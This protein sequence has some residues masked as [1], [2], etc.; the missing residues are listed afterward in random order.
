MSIRTL[1]GIIADKDG[2][3]PKPL[4]PPA[5]NAG[6]PFNEQ[7][8]ARGTPGTSS[9]VPR[10]LRSPVGRPGPGVVFGVL[11]FGTVM[12]LGIFAWLAWV[13][14][15]SLGQLVRGGSEATSAA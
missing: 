8:A 12:F 1:V 15:A 7:E 13:V 3:R 4:M 6:G 9:G 5:G 10:L 14:V 2:L 11:S